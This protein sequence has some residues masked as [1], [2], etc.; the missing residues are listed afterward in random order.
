MLKW[1]SRLVSE[2]SVAVHL[3]LALEVLVLVL[4]N[5]ES[6]ADGMQGSLMLACL[7][8]WMQQSAIYL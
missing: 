5:G 1:C 2:I 3:L 4:S 6:F 8:R 7:M